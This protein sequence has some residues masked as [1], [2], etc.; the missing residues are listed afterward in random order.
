MVVCIVIR[1]RHWVVEY[2]LVRLRDLSKLSKRNDHS[3]SFK[4]NQEVR[5]QCDQ[6]FRFQ[7]TG[8]DELDRGSFAIS[9][10]Q[11][12]WLDHSTE[13]LVLIISYHQQGVLSIEKSC[14]IFRYSRHIVLIREYLLSL[15]GSSGLGSQQT[16]CLPLPSLPPLTLL[17][18]RYRPTSLLEGLNQESLSLQDQFCSYDTMTV[19]AST[20]Q[21]TIGH[22]FETSLCVRNDFLSCYR[23]T[24]KHPGVLSGPTFLGEQIMV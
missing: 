20:Q 2:G 19:L 5:E 12:L 6:C 23:R 21:S 24:Q 8:A 9:I 4:N 18:S 15:A 13:D 7:H 10:L 16:H 17:C 3:H 22:R 1:G 11:H 14:F